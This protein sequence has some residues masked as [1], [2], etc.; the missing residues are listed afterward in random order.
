MAENSGVS[1]T[2]RPDGLPVGTPF[3][4]G[5]SGN[6]KGR[7]K[8]SHTLETMVRRILEGEEELPAAIAET[9]KAAVGEDKRAL[10]ATIIVGLLQALQG[11]KDWAKLLWE[12][13]YGKVP[14]KIIGDAEQPIAH[15]FTLKIDTK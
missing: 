2:K 5:Q 14:D 6:L 10:E 9:I 1:A 12:R 11:D 15:T 8:G 4:P 13:G 3:K 7:P